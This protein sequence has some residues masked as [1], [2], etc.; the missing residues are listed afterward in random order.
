MLP[1]IHTG[2]GIQLESESLELLNDSACD[3]GKTHCDDLARLTVDDT[4]SRNVHQTL[5]DIGDCANDSDLESGLVHIESHGTWGWR[6]PDCGAVGSV[7]P[8]E[9]ECPACDV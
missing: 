3:A 9:G 2:V 4:R 8:E 1:G 7:W 6:R 5:E